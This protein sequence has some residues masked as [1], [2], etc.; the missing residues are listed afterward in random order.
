MKAL[1]LDY[2]GVIVDD[3]PLHFASFRDV[4]AEEGI[5]LT[6]RE[7]A[8]EYLGIDDRAAFGK[9]FRRAGREAA[10]SALERRV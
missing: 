6:E 7:Y 2:N 9:A 4:L 8:A 3:E 5:P 10:P 1:L